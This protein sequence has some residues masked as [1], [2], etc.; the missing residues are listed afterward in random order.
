MIG[1]F[2]AALVALAVVACATPVAA[3]ATAMKVAVL[4]SRVL[5]D[6]APG[7]A[8]A[9]AAWDREFKQM[10]AEAGRMGDSLNLLIQDYQKVEATLSPAQ[11][12]ER[13]K[14][15][16]DKEAEFRRRTQELEDR[17]STRQAE[18]L[19]PMIELVNKV[20]QDVRNEDNY[21]LIFDLA[22][23]DNPLVAFDRN[24]DI[25]PRVL[26]KVRQQPAPPIKE[27][28]AKPAAQTPPP[29][30]P[31]SAAGAGVR[32]VPPPR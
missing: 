19:Q 9:S 25:T 18:L 26:A 17:A 4:D 27:A 24:L 13:Q 5:L 6:G 2:R 20:I 30:G 15:L 10:Q 29:A 23:D 31:T 1:S 3:Q 22:S 8:E 32:R 7:K 21:T 28:A 12:E 11:R 16:R 14:G